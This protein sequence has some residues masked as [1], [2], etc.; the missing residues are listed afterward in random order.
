V[1]VEVRALEIDAADLFEW[2]SK[3]LEQREQCPVGCELAQE[4]LVVQGDGSKCFRD[5]VCCS[6][7]LLIFSEC[8]VNLRDDSKDVEDLFGPEVLQL[9]QHD[10]GYVSFYALQ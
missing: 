2:A 1:A 9:D 10:R 7:L 6:M 4:F 5:L 8:P 3:Q